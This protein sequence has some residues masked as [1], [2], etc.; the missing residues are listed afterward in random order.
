MPR[1]LR[2]PLGEWPLHDRLLWTRATTPI[3]YFDTLAPAARWSPKTK[4]QAEAAYG[5]WLAFLRLHEPDA[6]QLSP[7]ARADQARLSRY[8]E[9]LSPRL[10]PISIAAEI[11]H[12]I[13]MLK[14]AVPNGDWGW[15]RGLQYR[16]EKV[17][18]PRERRNKILHPGRVFELGLALMN[19]ADA[20]ATEGARARQYR[21]GL[22]VALLAARPIRRRS[23]AELTIRDLRLVSER[24]VLV[25][26]ADTTKSRR[27][28]EFPLPTALTPYI[29]Q[30]V[31]HYRC[32]SP[33]ANEVDALWCST[34]GGALE[35]DAI[36]GLIIRRTKAAF[37]VAINP[38][39]F[40]HIAATAIAREAPGAMLLA[41][42]LL[43]HVNVET[44][45][46]HYCHATTLDAGREYDRVVE[47]LRELRRDR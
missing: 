39:L 13:L 20:Q 45:L 5:K 40:R 32:L 38:H 9:W 44:T 35:A 11:G 4:Y 6:L 18:V 36:Y 46:Q 14:I 42:D 8:V 34:K 25:L 43:T 29:V 30:Y 24:Y 2:L 31:G 37:G 28:T 15:L 26:R 19:D 27:E 41:S 17:A 3:D 7:A 1:A 10:R 21:D 16:C 22:A 33:R 12:L 47:R 23:F